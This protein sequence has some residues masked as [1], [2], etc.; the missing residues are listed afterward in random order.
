VASG[1]TAGTAMLG[2]QA[3]LGA[4]DAAGALALASAPVL[5]NPSPHGVTVLCATSG[6]ATGW[7]EYGPTEALG[8]RAD[9]SVDGMSPYA[10]RLL[11]FRI[12][13][14]RPGQKYFYRVHACPVEFRGAYD[15]RRGA[16]VRGDVL[17]FRTLDPGADKVSFTVW[18]DTH[19][20]ATTL[21]ALARSLRER[22][23]DFLLW[24]GDVTNDINDE[25]KVVGQFIHPAAQAFADKTPLLLGRGNHD[26]RGRFA[27][28]LPQYVP[29]PGGRYYYWFRQG[30]LA[31]LVLD[32]GED[33]PDGLPV[34][35]GLGR[36][37]DYR[38]EQARWLEKVIEEPLFKSA[39]HRVAFLHIPL[40]W[41]APVPEDWPAVWGK[42]IK[43]WVCEDG[44]AKWHDLLVRAKISVVLSGHTHSHAWFAPNDRRPYGQLIGG[45]PTPQEAI[46]ISGH[47]DARRLEL[48]M[49]KLDGSVVWR[50]EFRAEGA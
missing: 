18:N 24:N 40:V 28:R 26:V 39:P 29:G 30:P 46:E 47:A 49:K 9:G 12:D 8:E 5:L 45:G 36:F 50:E 17:S 14:L 10:D 38:T 31:A 4:A 11:S 2:S 23:D 16:E 6:P 22:R 42:G 32:T 27:R 37:A 19:E 43:G 7:V 48:T 3:L 1:A 25:S 35:A 41:E 44:L 20:N 21:A 34:Y 33:K 15:I 13:G